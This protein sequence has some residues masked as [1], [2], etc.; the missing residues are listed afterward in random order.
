MRE[1]AMTVSRLQQS[2]VKPN[3]FV[4]NAVPMPTGKYGYG[5]GYGKYRY[6]YQYDYR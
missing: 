3:G 1:I 5:Y 6:H 4:F 2:G